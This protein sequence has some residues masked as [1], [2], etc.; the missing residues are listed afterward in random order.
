[1]NA[2][3][4]KDTLILF[5]SLIAVIILITICFRNSMRFSW[6]KKCV[7]TVIALERIK[8]LL[9]YRVYIIRYYIRYCVVVQCSFLTLLIFQHQCSYTINVLGF[10]WQ[11]NT[12]G[13][14]NY[15]KIW[16][17]GYFYLWF[18]IMSLYLVP[19][20]SVK[21]TNLYMDQCASTDISI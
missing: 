13:C 20:I 1:M 10:S 7:S 5:N 19:S 17:I 2:H 21:D 14:I 3:F 6:F 16:I 12:T 18:Q 9:V 8:K 11:R 4:L 15:Q